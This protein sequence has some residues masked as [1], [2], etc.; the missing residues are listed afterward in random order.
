MQQ[1]VVIL[2]MYQLSATLIRMNI[3]QNNSKD[4]PT[5][6]EFFFN[7]FVREDINSTRTVVYKR[8]KKIK[9]IVCPLY[10]SRYDE[11]IDC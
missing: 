2:I 8:R 1:Q 7:N 9:D 10:L 5:L 3:L 4:H 11:F 6:S